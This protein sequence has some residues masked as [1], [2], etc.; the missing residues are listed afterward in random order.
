VVFGF[1]H[2]AISDFGVLADASVGAPIKLGSVTEIVPEI[3]AEASLT[4]NS[5][6]TAG[7]KAPIIG[8]LGKIKFN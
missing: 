1:E 3:K 5:G 4:I 2:G 8:S 7:V 6:F